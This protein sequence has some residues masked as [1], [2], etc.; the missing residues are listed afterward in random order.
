VTVAGGTAPTE[1]VCSLAD[2]SEVLV[3]ECAYPDG[4]ESAGHSR[5][6]ALGKLLAAVEVDHILLT[7]LFPETEPYADE[8]VGTVSKY[9]DTTVDVAA[10]HTSM[11]LN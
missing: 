7:Y 2:R 11:A 8:L 3:H 10:D 4:T 6:T 9:T 1:S 5:P